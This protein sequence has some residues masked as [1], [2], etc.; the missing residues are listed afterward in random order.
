MVALPAAGEDVSPGWERHAVED[1]IDAAPDAVCAVLLDL[2]AFP[3]WFPGIEEWRLLDAE[4]Q[5]PRIV[6]VPVYGRQ[7]G[8][9]PFRDRDYV[10]HYSYSSM[11]DGGCRL[12]A[13]ALADAEPAATGSTVRIDSMRTLW[14]VHP[15]GSGAQ[16]GY[17]VEIAPRLIPD[18]ATPERFRVAPERL[19]ELLAEEV[20]RRGGP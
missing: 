3:R 15:Y 17:A 18:W 7:R 13:L 5:D 4:R 9:G 10:V 14:S 12:E 1:R 11:E 16:V 2:P 8:F 19:I 6:A 20:E